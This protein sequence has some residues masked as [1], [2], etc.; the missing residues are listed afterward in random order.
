MRKFEHLNQL[1]SE[2]I[3]AQLNLHVGQLPFPDSDKRLFGPLGEP[4][5]RCAVH[6]RREHSKPRLKNIALKI[7]PKNLPKATS[8]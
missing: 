6:Q 2:F 7:N 4:V 3:K 8:P 5:D 1:R